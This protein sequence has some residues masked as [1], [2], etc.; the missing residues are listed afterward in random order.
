MRFRIK[1]I[2]LFVWTCTVME[3]AARRLTEFLPTKGRPRTAI[4]VCPGG[5]YCW[6][7]KKTEGTE[8]AHWLNENGIAAYV[9]H[10]P[11]AGWAAFAWH[12]R[13]LF[14]GR[15]HP[16]QFDAINAA[17][18][19]IRSKGYAHVGAMGFSAGGHLVLLAAE[20]APRSIAP[21]FIAAL[22]PVVSLSAPCTHRRS[23]RGLLGEYRRHDTSLCDSLSMEKHADRIDCPTFLI[24][25]EDD[26]I[27]NEHNAELM[28]SAL[29]ANR[30]PHYF[31]Q[32]KTG[33]HGFGV[34]ES[35]TSHEAIGWKQRF[36]AWLRQI[37]G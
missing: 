1:I 17:L 25:C 9:L 26:P 10:Y 33:G 16:D 6:L 35:K 27:V 14:R 15:Q 8:V 34:D 22:Y 28:D 4:I 12:T 24:N 36:M 20:Y 30:K 21:D 23:R 37:F 29:T 13:L 5:S 19:E 18:R 31:H 11:T 7:S 3:T 32:Y 2:L